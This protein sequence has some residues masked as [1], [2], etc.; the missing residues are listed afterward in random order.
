MLFQVELIA[1]APE[2]FLV[3]ITHCLIIYGVICTTSSNL[4]FPIL[5]NILS[6]LSIQILFYSCFLTFYNPLSYTFSFNNLL[7][8]DEFSIFIKTIIIITALCT[9]LIS[10][11]YNQFERINAFELIILLLLAVTG[12]LL[13]VS[14]FNFIAIY[15]AIELQSFC[16]YILAALNR[17]SEFSTEA[18]LKYF[19][20]GAFSSGLLLFGLSLVYGFTGIANLGEL[21]Q[22]LS[23][24]SYNLYILNGINLGSVFIIVGLFFKLSAAPFHL[25]APDIYEGSLT[26]ITVFFAIVPKIGILALLTRFS[27]LGFYDI[28]FSWQELLIVSS[29]CSILLGTFAAITQLKLKRLL[30]YSAIGHIGYMLMGF[31]CGCFEGIQATY[32][33]IV[34]YMVMSIVSFILLLGLYKKKNLIRINYLKDLGIL[35]NS[36]PLIA[37][38]IIITFFS[39][40]GI[41]PLSGFFSKMFLFIVAIQ[42]FMYTVA[43][44]AVI[45]SVV[46]C[47]YYLRIVK[48]IFFDIDYLWLTLSRF[49]REKS[50]VLSIL[51][52]FVLFVAIYPLPIIYG[53]QNILYFVIRNQMDSFYV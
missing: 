31:S 37:K 42:S 4:Y 17:K 45:T 15:L 50:I 19:I 46:S 5:L 25:W 7:I 3:S 14:S 8:L 1:M 13:L 34:L 24:N 27:Y 44:I 39:M 20:L 11:K 2:I 10:I 48:L 21:F 32:I 23:I 9:I 33:Y 29:I 16:L 22:F 26:S 36:N 52:T 49:D 35:A 51:T 38:I 40:A 30:A 18:G 12:I 43:I 41:P 28:F 53:I 6:W 47:F